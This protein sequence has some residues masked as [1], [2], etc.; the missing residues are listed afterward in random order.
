MYL[1]AV[2][3]GGKVKGDNGVDA[4][5]F[6]CVDNF[7][8]E[9][10]V[11]VVE[12]RV[13]DEVRLHGVLVAYVCHLLDVRERHVVGGTRAHIELGN[14]KVDTVA[15]RLYGGR[16]TLKTP[17]GRHYLRVFRSY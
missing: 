3:Y 4:V 7:L 5:L 8:H 17:C 10:C 6:S 2:L 12:E 1:V 13:H 15:P 11:V 14:T 16:E 9:V